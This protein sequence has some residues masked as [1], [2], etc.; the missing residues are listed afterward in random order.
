MLECAT[1]AF[2]SGLVLDSKCSTA[3]W[4]E[5]RSV[6]SLGAWG[7]Q[8]HTLAFFWHTSLR[9]CYPASLPVVA[10]SITGLSC[11]RWKRVT[12][13]CGEH[14]VEAPGIGFTVCS[15]E[16]CVWTSSEWHVLHLQH[17]SCP[18][19]PASCLASQWETD[20][21]AERGDSSSL[22]L[23]QAQSIL[24]PHSG[25]LL[26]PTAFLRGNAI[27]SRLSW[28]VCGSFSISITEKHW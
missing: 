28:Q 15:C 10:P 11:V 5:Q 13:Q 20:P 3:F 12:Q 27:R 14:T 1:L 9:H 6:R 26:A 24:L 19:C 7:T 2:P 22:G 4:V 25:A 16:C 21:R 23:G 8:I 18:G 17:S